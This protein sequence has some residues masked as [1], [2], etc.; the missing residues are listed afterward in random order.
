MRFYLK[1]NRGRQDKRRGFILILFITTVAT[2]SALLLAALSIY[3]NP[4]IEIS[5]EKSR[6]TSARANLFSCKELFMR[7]LAADFYA[8]D[9]VENGYVYFEEGSI[10]CVFEGVQDV[11]LQDILNYYPAN[12]Y[13]KI[14]NTYPSNTLYARYRIVHLTTHDVL[15]VEHS[16]YLFLYS[17]VFALKEIQTFFFVSD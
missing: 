6:L 7:K 4:L 16:G 14:G 11:S 8:D 5:R 9:G 2:S 12:L 17:D 3:M 15:G 1:N 10:K 13:S